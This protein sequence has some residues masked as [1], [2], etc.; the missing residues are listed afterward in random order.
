MEQWYISLLAKYAGG[1]ETKK[2][3]V[4]I[5]QFGVVD[6]HRN[7]PSYADEASDMDAAHL[8]MRDDA[9][10]TAMENANKASRASRGARRRGCANPRA[11]RSRC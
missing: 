9:F 10:R 5:K 8:A 6:N 11:R 7:A 2:R 4:V 1:G 3:L